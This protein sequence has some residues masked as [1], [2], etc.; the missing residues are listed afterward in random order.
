[1]QEDGLTFLG[2]GVLGQGILSGKYDR[3]ST[4]DDSDRRSNNRYSN[5]HGAKLQ[6]NLR[7][8]E[9]MKSISDQ[10]PGSTIAEVA[11]SWALHKLPSGHI[12]AGIKNLK[13]LKNNMRV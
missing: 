8:V 1:M 5:F 4:F 7:I 13:Q 10:H 3:N 11:L 12:I 9:A 2:F 6:H